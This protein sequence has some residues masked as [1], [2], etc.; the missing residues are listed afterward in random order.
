MYE[1]AAN[2]VEL[3]ERLRQWPMYRGLA[4]SHTIAYAHARLKED[5]A[6]A[7]DRCRDSGDTARAAILEQ[8]LLEWDHPQFWDYFAAKINS[9]D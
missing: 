7:I 4:R 5:L 2:A 3:C 9:N 6:G 1:Q 8:A